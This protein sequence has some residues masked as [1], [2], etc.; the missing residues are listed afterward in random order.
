M[1]CFFGVLSVRIIT[2]V[3]VIAVDISGFQV[4]PLWFT[5]GPWLLAAGADRIAQVDFVTFII[6][7]L[8][9]C[10][11][12]KMKLFI[13][14]LVVYQDILDSACDL[15]LLKR[16]FGD[17][18]VKKKSIVNP[19]C[20]HADD[21][22]RYWCLHLLDLTFVRCKSVFIHPLLVALQ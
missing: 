10:W 13:R 1:R 20:F 4:K 15:R 22:R 9:A 6:I 7:I 14:T 3:N 5:C 2:I 18:M 21:I 16:H 8:V 11:N 12:P 19:C 17:Q